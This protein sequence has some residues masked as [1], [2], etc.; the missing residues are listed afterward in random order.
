M[1]YRLL[2]PYLLILSLFHAAYRERVRPTLAEQNESFC[3]SYVKYKI[4][5]L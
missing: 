4:E 2:S 3:N 1:R 5:L